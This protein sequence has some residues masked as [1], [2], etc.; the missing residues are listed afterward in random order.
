MDT[1]VGFT[2]TQLGIF[3]DFDRARYYHIYSIKYLIDSRESD[4]VISIIACHLFVSQY[5]DY[6]GCESHT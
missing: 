2:C 6:E 1:R 3:L 5:S 4:S